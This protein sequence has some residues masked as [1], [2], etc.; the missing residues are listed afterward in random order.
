MGWNHYN[1]MSA[2][3]SRA[4]QREKEAQEK[5][6]E[7]KEEFEQNV[8]AKLAVGDKHRIEL[9]DPGLHLTAY[10][11]GTFRSWLEENH[12]G[13]SAKRRQASKETCK[14][15]GSQSRGK[16]YFVDV[17]YQDPSTI[18]PKKKRK[19][20][21]EEEEEEGL[22]A[23][24]KPKAIPAPPQNR[25]GPFPLCSLPEQL[26]LSVLGFVDVA[27]LGNTLRVSKHLCA[28]A[29][30]DDLWAPHLKY[31]LEELFDGSL[32]NH[33]MPISQRPDWQES[34]AFRRWY[35]EPREGG[36]KM[37]CKNTIG[38]CGALE[39]IDEFE[40][41][42]ELYEGSEEEFKWLLENVALREYYKQAGALAAEGVSQHFRLMEVSFDDSP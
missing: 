13:W 30:R 18:K 12:P 8:L 6:E 11:W 34:T 19:K 25:V 23:A 16:G 15:L 10:T 42:P 32:G 22:E 4:L 14:R 41:H 33:P 37:I 17:I 9:L 29:K 36:Y 38:G 40:D 35:E 24:K 20:K 2:V 39:N 5:F 27:T 7:A 31:L 1:F 28:L 26:Q 21:A 3:S